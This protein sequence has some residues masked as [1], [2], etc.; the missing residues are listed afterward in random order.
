MITVVD[1][2][3]TYAVLGIWS[4]FWSDPNDLSG[5]SLIVSWEIL[6]QRVD[7][8][9][10]GTSITVAFHLAIINIFAIDYLYVPPPQI[11][12]FKPIPT[13]VIVFGGEDLGGD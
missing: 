9:F 1:P 11:H 4:C 13:N 7:S 6:R 10:P 8:L 2:V 5:T 3:M 12:I